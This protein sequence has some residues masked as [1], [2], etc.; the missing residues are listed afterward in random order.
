[1]C[2]K[3]GSYGKP[4][5]VKLYMPDEIIEYANDN[6]HTVAPSILE[7]AKKNANSS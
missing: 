3:G 2:L 6:D 1:V 5:P 4:G 7:K